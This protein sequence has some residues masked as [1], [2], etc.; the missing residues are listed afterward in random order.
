MFT[1]QSYLCFPFSIMPVFQPF[2]LFQMYPCLSSLHKALP[3]FSFKLNSCTT[4]FM[5]HFVIIFLSF[6]IDTTTPIKNKK[7]F[8]VLC[9]QYPLSLKIVC[10]YFSS[11]AMEERLGMQ[12][13]IFLVF[14]CPLAEKFHLYCKY[15]EQFFKVFIYFGI[16]C[17]MHRQIKP[18]QILLIYNSWQLTTVDYVSSLY[19]CDIVL[20]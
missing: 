11:M 15:S 3:G 14:V 18:Y 9:I 4:S 13:L 12:T 19:S 7:K 6:K 1:G 8:S 2:S 16:I 10:A 17:F 5:K 20:G